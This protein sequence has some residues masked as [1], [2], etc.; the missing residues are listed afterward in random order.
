MP[1]LVLGPLLRHAGPSDATVWVETDAPCEVEVLGCRASTFRVG[2][3][4]YALVVVEGLAPGTCREYEVRL[5]GEKRW[6][7]PGSPFPPS[8]IR[9]LGGGEPVKLV[10]GSCRISAPHETP[11]TLTHEED[12][13]GLGVDA[14]FAWPRG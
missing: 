7:E 10:F 3:H 14:L 1:E 2:G 4:H 12:E 9:T 6:P 8:V 11:Y 5:D 13:R